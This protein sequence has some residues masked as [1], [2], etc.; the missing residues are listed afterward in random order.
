MIRKEIEISYQ[1]A[2]F[3]EIARK[4]TFIKYLIEKENIKAAKDLILSYKEK[5]N[6][7]LNKYKDKAEIIPI[8]CA[9]LMEFIEKEGRDNIY[10]VTS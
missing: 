10:K 3:S 7:L 2:V 8:P 6:L 4:Q 9:G 5:F 1:D